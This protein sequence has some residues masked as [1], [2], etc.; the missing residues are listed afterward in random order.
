[1][2]ASALRTLSAPGV[3]GALM[4]LGL[5]A[6]A[7]PARTPPPAPA[8]AWITNQ[9]SDDVSVID[10]QA[11]RVVATVPSG[12]APAGVA[13]LP[14]RGEVAVAHA[15]DGSIGLI[16]IATRREVARIAA[17]AGTVGVAASADGRRLFAADWHGQA[18]VVIDPATR[19]VLRRVPLGRAPAGLAVQADGR[20]VWVA[21][22]DDDRVALVDAEAGT[23]LARIGVGAG[24]HPFALL[25]DEPRGRLLV[26]GVQD[27][28]LSVIDLARR[29]LLR[30]LPTGRAPYAAVLADAGRR[31]HVSSQ[32]D[33]RI[34]V[35]DA[36]T[37]AP[38][39]TVGDLAWPE[40][41]D[42]HGGEVWAV[43]WM[44]D[45]VVALDAASGRLLARIP[46]GRNP[47]GFGHF[48]SV[49]DTPA[50][51]SPGD[52]SR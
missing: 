26:L 39:G 10:L 37:L 43:S 13:V 44:D 47:R 41:L 6:H 14:G 28:R 34:D 20:H 24:A 33:D 32:Q 4:A 9:G 1:M 42:A 17:G 49:D 25:L 51:P 12:P 2:S 27:S 36:D 18:L 3:I 38:L 46:V 29:E 31:L 11:R 48:V 5:P 8:L 7:Q 21:E 15:G 45:A 52:R 22:R 35:F 30:Q 23:L 16:D 40:G 19:Q 50:S